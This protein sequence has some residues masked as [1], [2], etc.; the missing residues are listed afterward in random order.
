MTFLGD[1]YRVRMGSD[2]GLVALPEQN[3]AAYKWVSRLYA[4]GAQGADGSMRGAFSRL[5]RMFDRF[6]SGLPSRNF[7]IDLKTGEIQAT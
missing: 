5:F 2:L 7:A 4:C 1:W 3:L 6:I